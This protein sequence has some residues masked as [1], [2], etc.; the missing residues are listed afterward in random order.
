MTATHKLRKTLTKIPTMA[1][2]KNSK[3]TS[4]A[5]PAAAPGLLAAE[6]AAPPF[7]MRAEAP[8]VWTD[9]LN[10]YVDM[11]Q[12][13]VLFLDVL[14]ERGDNML[15]H[16]RAG[17]P[18]LLDFEHD[19]ILDARTFERPA[20]YALLRI[21]RCGP[22]HASNFERQD[23]RPV[24]VVD[25]RAGHGPG[26]GGFKHDSE[27]GVA[28]HEGHPTYFAI[29]YPEP[30]PG[31]TLA[32]VIHALRN[33]AQEIKRRHGGTAPVL[34]GNC[35]GGWAVMLLTADCEGLDA[36]AVLNGS[37]L[38]YW[39]G[40]EDVNPMRLAGGL[41]GG[42]WLTHLM[43][44]LG[45]GRLDGAWLV[46]NFEKLNPVNTLWQKNYNLFAN[47]DTE[48]DRFLEFE[49][50]WSS[51]YFL[52]REEI[53]STVENLFIGNRL[54]QGQL[55]LDT[56]DMEDH[57]ACV[58]DLKQI[59]NPIVVFASSGDNITPPHQALAWVPAIYPDTATL[60]AAGQRIIYLL[61]THVG[62]LG[63]FVSATVAQHEH[64]AILENVEAYKDLAPGLYEMKID[65]SADDPAADGTAK[66][67]S[68][69]AEL[70]KLGVRFEERRV[71]DLQFEYPRRAF[72]K[73]DALSQWNE[74]IYRT[75][76]SPWIKA[77]ANPVSSFLQKWGHPMRVQ[78]YLFSPQITPAMAWVPFAVAWV[79]QTRQPVSDDNP[80]HVSE[81]EA[82]QAIA[83]AQEQWRV[84]RDAA[85]EQLFAQ[86]YGET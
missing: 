84:K 5:L 85:Q 65:A 82:S 30:C 54:E 64:R 21:T 35:Q 72:E 78:R 42:A 25:P 12:R 24:M 14:R 13:S 53:L 80:L 37:P 55:R 43:A 7:S 77:S 23:L 52:S 33:F 22:T 32:D 1:P 29:F 47:V 61:N 9:S 10:Y 8:K 27:V 81:L 51:Y 67:R 40:A 50:W 60:K 69:K 73:V 83:D 3:A 76:V 16:E 34:Y 4:V 48:R 45:G 18:P 6:V 41:L 58:I 38:S 74:S 56:C 44:D 11:V 71:E 75:W 15:A 49:R 31:Q 17:Q 63:L 68:R 79:K 70:G 59:R 57:A 62:H 19:L 46:E 39:A 2:T 36:P 86:L 66:P 20:N 26:I 28:L